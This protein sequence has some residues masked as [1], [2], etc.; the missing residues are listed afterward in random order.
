MP[1]SVRPGARD[2]LENVRCP[3]RDHPAPLPWLAAAE[4]EW[5]L[6]VRIRMKARPL[7]LRHAPSGEI[8]GVI[9]TRAPQEQLQLLQPG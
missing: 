6:G 3:S 1:R 4:Q 7:E 5:H 8:T 2:S 9:N